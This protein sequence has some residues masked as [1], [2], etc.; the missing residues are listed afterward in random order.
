MIIKCMEKIDVLNIYNA[1]K[2]PEIINRLIKHSTI[3]RLVKNLNSKF[4]TKKLGYSVLGKEI[5]S[6]EFGE[7]KRNILLWSQMHGNEPTATGAIFDL[8]NLFD[9]YSETELVSALKREFKFTFIPM[10]NPDG[11]RNWTRVNALNIDL[12]RDAIV[13][14]APESKILWKLVE[15]LKPEYSFNLHDQRNIFNV[16]ET[17]KTATVS[18]LSASFDESRA[19]NND[20]ALTMSLIAEMNDTVQE[21]MPGH[22]GRYTD[23]FYPTATGDNLHKSGFKN[24]L[25]ESGTYPNDSERQITRKANFMA[26][27]RAF[28]VI[29]NGVKTDRTEDYTNI[30]NNAKRLYDLIIRNV[31]ISSN[32]T[33]SL[34]D[35]GI[36]YNERPDADY[37]NMI[38]KSHIEN[39][40]DLSQYF[41]I[42]EINAK[43]ALFFDGVKHFASL[44]QEANFEIGEKIK[45]VNG[46]IVM[47]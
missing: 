42:Q 17:D 28:E 12:N 35:F 11:A 16:G 15:D 19:I 2:E 4:K 31:R 30:P 40:G 6:I 45:V 8:L 32:S 24:I 26:I 29:L 22:V 41:G 38:K 7:G 13:R 43:G 36:M 25:I 34:V 3:K 37:R 23:E 46:E 27:L 9:Q 5:Y 39:I 1:I 21:L 18:F 10:L 20:R 14:E 33:S 47:H 44:K